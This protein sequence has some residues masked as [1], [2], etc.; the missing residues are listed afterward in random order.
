M[1]KAIYFL[2]FTLNIINS[3]CFLPHSLPML[4][5]A[6]SLKMTNN[7][8]DNINNREISKLYTSPEAYL[9]TKK[10]I[11]TE[12]LIN[13]KDI[14]NES[15]IIEETKNIIRK[16]NINIKNIYVN[17]FENFTN[18]NNSKYELLENHGF[19]SILLNIYN[20]DKIIMS[21]NSKHIICKLRDNL[22]N[23]YYINEYGRIT[24]LATERLHPNK[25]KNFII[26]NISNINIDGILYTE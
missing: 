18:T 19:N 6:M 26:T 25:I 11:Y 8:L 20:F 16:N 7:N 5:Q 21:Y 17:Y 23:L 3:V 2:L 10:D 15:F 4:K 14:L 24:E 1:T 22:K 9:V 13:T 12:Q